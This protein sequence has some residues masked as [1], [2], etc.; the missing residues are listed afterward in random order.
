[1]KLNAVVLGGVISVVA[2]GAVAS[3]GDSTPTADEDWGPLA[4]ARG[5]ASGQ[6]A[7]LEGTLRIDDKCVTVET[8]GERLL[9]VWPSD[10]T[11]W[12]ADAET[13]T[14]EATDD[15]SEVLLRSGDEVRIGG[16]GWA[17]GEDEGDPAEWAGTTEWVNEPA[18][19]CLTDTRFF[20]G[21]LQT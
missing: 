2:L 15:G 20:L 7:G 6:E 3:C 10:S 1:V 21:T 16:G 11:K 13:I 14:Y 17:A 4:V 5:D 9:V 19:E 18:E 8:G 12:D